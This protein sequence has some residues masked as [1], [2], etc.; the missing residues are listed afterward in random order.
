MNAMTLLT[1]AM[2]QV[3]HCFIPPWVT[4]RILQKGKLRLREGSVDV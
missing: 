3:H 4:C 1:F 2:K